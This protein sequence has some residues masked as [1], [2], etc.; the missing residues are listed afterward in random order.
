MWGL[1][2]LVWEVFNGRSLEAMGQLGKIGSIP[3]GMAPTYMELV[4]KNPS[5]RPDPSAKVC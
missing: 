2:C 4:A 3:K 1:G 5:K